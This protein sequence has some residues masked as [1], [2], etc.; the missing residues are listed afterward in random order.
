MTWQLT[1]AGTFKLRRG[2]TSCDRTKPTERTTANGA[3]RI[4][5]LLMATSPFVFVVHPSAAAENN[6]G[7]QL[8]A[9]C[10]SCHRLDGR[11]QGIPSIVGL[12]KR[13]LADMMEA[14][15]SG[16]RSSQIMNVV[17]RSLSTE[18]IAALADYLA[19]RQKGSE[20]P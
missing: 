18:E 19:A 20:Q 6:R 4:L 5:A 17:A 2:R 11:D 10:A 3:R 9:M 13:K 8:A 15:K 14:F 7:A 1:S 12:D 16:K